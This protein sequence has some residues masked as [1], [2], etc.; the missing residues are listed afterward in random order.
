MTKSRK[1]FD[2]GIKDAELML[3][4]YKVHPKESPESGEALKRAG[5]VLAL[6]AW[7]TYIEDLIAER[8]D[9]YTQVLHGSPAGTFMKKR[10]EIELKQF[11]NPNSAKTQ[12]LFKDFLEI[13]IT[14]EWHWD[15][16]DIT[17]VKERLDHYL[18]MRGD[19]VHRA[20]VVEAGVP[21]APHIVKKD[22]LDKAIRFLKGLVDATE[23]RFSR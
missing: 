23:R 17:K 8:V 9:A 10:L 14:E 18:S 3:E 2:A 12:K 19:A 7:E 15:N 5:L 13:D 6:T 21:S 20:R 16:F 4:L 22:D 1:S 11:H